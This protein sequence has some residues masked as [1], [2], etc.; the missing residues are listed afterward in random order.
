MFFEVRVLSNTPYEI[1]THG[2]FRIVFINFRYSS[3]LII[4]LDSFFG[5]CV[6]FYGFFHFSVFRF[7]LTA[8]N[9]VY[10]SE[11]SV[12]KRCKRIHVQLSGEVLYKC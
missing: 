2:L 9:V 6:Y 4:Y 7:V 10:L 12:C 5:Q 11:C 3:V 8:Q 1:L